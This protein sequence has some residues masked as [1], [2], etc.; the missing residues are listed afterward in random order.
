MAQFLALYSGD[1]PD[2]A[3]VV[4]VSTNPDLVRR[5]ASDLL[6]DP[7]FKAHATNDPV[8]SALAAGRRRA[9]RLVAGGAANE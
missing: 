1:R 8:T 7:K 9:L 2:N 6:D 4:A 5:F 3:Q